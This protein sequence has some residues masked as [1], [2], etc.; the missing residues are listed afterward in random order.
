MAT[1]QAESDAA[2]APAAAPAPKSGGKLVLII[3]LLAIVITAQAVITWL[4]M[5]S[6]Q[7]PKPADPAAQTEI[8]EKTDEPADPVE[9]DVAE[10]P[11]GDFNCTNN[12]AAPGVVMHV[13]F[14]LAAL[15][16]NRQSSALESQL[17]QHQGRVRQLVSKVIRSSNLEELNDPNLGTI[18]R[19]VRE[20]INRLLRKSYITEIIITDIRTMEQ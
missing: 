8:P 7:P 5:P 14:K 4:L 19:L 11:I 20:E 12:T 6:A 10:V 9:S 18:K 15:T 2:A 16:S 1:K 17:K 13:D 3:G